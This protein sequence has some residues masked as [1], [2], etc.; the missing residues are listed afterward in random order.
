M[1]GGEVI[2]VGFK[3]YRHF[4]SLLPLL[5]SNVAAGTCTWMCTGVSQWKVVQ[6]LHPGRGVGSCSTSSHAL[7]RHVAM[8]LAS[9][10]LPTLARPASCESSQQ[11]R[12]AMPVYCC[13]GVLYLDSFHC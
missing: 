10:W 9:V 8:D 12:M 5:H 1:H 4:N 2:S 13:A 6:E 3:L 11:Q 7:P